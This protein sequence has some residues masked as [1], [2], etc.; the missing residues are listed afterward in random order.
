MQIGDITTVNGQQIP[1][2]APPVGYTGR[3]RVKGSAKICSSF[4][5]AQSEITIVK[6]KERQKQIGEQTS[7][8]QHI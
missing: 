2:S 1:L 5:E 3:Y 8:L 7:Y 4:E 6:L